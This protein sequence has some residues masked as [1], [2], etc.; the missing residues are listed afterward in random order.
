MRNL[1]FNSCAVSSALIKNIDRNKKVILDAAFDTR[2]CS[3][4][5]NEDDLEKS[6]EFLKNIKSSDSNRL[7][8]KPKG[9]ILMIL[10]FNEPLLMSIVPIFNALLAGN[11]VVLRPSSKCKALVRLIWNSEILEILDKGSLIIKDFDYADLDIEVQGMSAVYFFGS[12]KNAKSVYL[13]CAKNFVQ[14]FP[15]LEASDLAVFDRV[16]VLGKIQKFTRNFIKDI[17][18]H[19]GKMCQ[20]L[21]GLLVHKSTY[22]LL[23][24]SLICNFGFREIS[25]EYLLSNLDLNPQLLADVVESRPKRLFYN[26]SVLLVDKPERVSDLYVSAYFEK[27]AWLDVFLNYHELIDV[28]DKRV[29]RLGLS[30]S[31]EDPKFINNLIQDTQFSRYTINRRHT[32]ISSDTGWGGIWPTGSGGYEDWLVHFSNLSCIIR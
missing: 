9:D 4:K 13:S 14:F 30:I 15:E 12:L 31:S 22:D 24:T 32:P 25:E 26:G 28:L 29:F 8:L 6:I 16:D 21:G 27:V 1:K 11:K 2:A 23:I 17:E 18:D 19:D 20:K 7:N 3:R 5:D 10:S